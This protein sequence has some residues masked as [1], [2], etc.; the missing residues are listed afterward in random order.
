MRTTS[1][2]CGR[3][4]D[5]R[6]RLDRVIAT[7]GMGTVYEGFDSRLERTVAVKVMNHDLVD[8]PGFTDRFVTEARAAARLSD[9]H[10][11]SVFDRGRSADAVYLVMEYVPG[12]TLREELKWGGRLPVAR[13]LDILAGVLEGLAA[14]HTAGF[15]HGDVK[16]ENVLLDERGDVKVTDFG[17]A[18]AI[19]D[20]DHK[21]SLLM[22]TAAYLAPE[23][24]TRR[25][26]DPRSDLYSAGI[27]LFEMLTGHVP[28]RAESPDDVLALHRTHAVPLPSTFV[29]VGDELDELCQKATARDP[30]DRFATAGEMLAVVLRLRYAADPAAP[31]PARRS[32]VPAIPVPAPQG[33]TRVV[34]TEM[35]GPA[36]EPVVAPVVPVALEADDVDLRDAAEPTATDGSG[37]AEPG[38]FRPRKRRRGLGLLLVAV[39]ATLVGYA[40]WEFG[41]TQTVNTPK[42]AGMTRSEALAA[43]NEVGLTM[44]VVEERYSE[45]RK[46]GHIIRSDPRGGE[47]VA[48]SGTVD[49][50]MS[51]GP[52]RFRVPDVRGMSQE[53]AGNALNGVN[54]QVGD[55]L[56]R[57]SRAIALGSVI[58]TDPAKGTALKRGTAVSLVVSQGPRPVAVPDVRGMTVDQATAALSD[59]GLKS[60]VEEQYDEDIEFGRA[61]GT[62]PASGTT[63][64]RGDRVT[65]LVSKGSQY[66]S[67]PSVVGM[68]TDAA[69]KLLQDAGFPVST[70]EQFGVTVANRVISQN[71]SGGSRVLPGT[72]VTLTIT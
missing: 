13:T 61:V 53:A 14:A 46:A 3:V 58:R 24:A 26:P 4:L 63:V 15:V 48:A 21:A 2:L 27:L 17:L 7:G 71:P 11:V 67:V 37:T 20:A 33:Q 45:K 18:R 44:R 68:E 36:E 5:A 51:K 52:E 70:R 29:E 8:E 12:R 57:Y 55:I 69:R 72:P 38:P 43:L 19:G 9:R 47:K 34:P 28:F 59:S 22:G 41:T 42:L 25:T 56:P 66:V 10:V 50:V 62:E 39:L 23:Q 6:Y 31:V 16:P 60:R 65:L 40:A 54:L 30:G 32:A 35:V 64:Y 49:V 1:D